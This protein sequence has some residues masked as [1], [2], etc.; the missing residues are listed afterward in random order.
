MKSRKMSS[1]V[2]T[3]YAIRTAAFLY[4]AWETLRGG[5]MVYFEAAA[6]IVTLILLGQVLE[7]RARSAT[8]GRAGK[9]GRTCCN[10][11][12]RCPPRRRSIEASLRS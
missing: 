2:R 9:N 5:H 8:G 4:S 6:A 11:S 7:L 10:S 12:R 3:N 1:V